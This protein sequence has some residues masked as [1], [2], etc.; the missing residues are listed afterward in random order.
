MKAWTVVIP[1]LILGLGSCESPPKPSGEDVVAMAAGFEFKAETAAEILAPQPQ[2]PNQP[3]VVQ[4]LADLWV[5]YFLLALASEEDT[6]LASIDVSSMV[7]RQVEGEM[8]GQLRD[9]VIQVD[10]VIPDDE[11][12]LRYT[13]ELPGGRIRARHILLQFPPEATDAEVD[14]VRALAASIRSR[15]L[16][17]E[18]F[19]DLA[20]EY[21]QDSET[22]SQGGDLGSFGR[23]EM[24]PAFEEAAFGLEV[25]EISDV[26]E[27]TFGLHIIR[28]DERIIPSFEERKDQFRTEV[29]TKMVMEAESTY[30]AKLVDAAAWETEPESFETIR[31]LASD[32]EMELTS[33]ALARPLVRYRG[34]EL[35]L[36][37]F[38]AW[39]MENPNDIFAQIQAASDT[40]LENLLQS[41]TR[42][43]L[44][45]NEARS[46]GLEISA[47]RRDSLS[48]GI[49]AGVKGIARELG[50]FQIEPQEGENPKTAAD[51][52]VR[53]ILV[54]I[55]QQQRDVFPL[56]NIAFLLR[57]Q[58]GARIYQPGI[59]RTVELV[60]QIRAETPPA[61]L[62]SAPVDTMGPDTTGA[63][64]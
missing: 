26:V 22:A 43:E 2:L 56:Q 21:S 36:G 41:L 1:T 48:Q 39:L 64:G 46:E 58:Y 35:T 42:S 54:Q 61:P 33:R 50:F 37:E 52:V 14:S 19:E 40:Q 7:D 53:E 25:G 4:A 28:L 23:N 38:R 32:P 24:V 13:Q 29:Q 20:R 55:V 30:V 3:E 10:T 8:V 6:T 12:R 57:E 16:G 17:G 45:V 31:Q 27:T 11:L 18:S 47:A 51:R 9:L 5:Q 15:I 49:L 62:P 60:D 34:G 59:Q 44:L 63:Q